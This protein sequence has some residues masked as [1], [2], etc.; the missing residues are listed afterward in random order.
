MVAL[1]ENSKFAGM[2]VLRNV[3][4]GTVHI[5]LKLLPIASSGH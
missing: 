2:T 3:C 4:T 1:V 5:G